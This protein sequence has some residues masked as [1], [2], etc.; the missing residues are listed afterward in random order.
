MRQNSINY[1]YSEIPLRII[2]LDKEIIIKRVR[3]IELIIK[4]FRQRW[5]HSVFP[6]TRPT[7]SGV[8]SL[9][10]CIWLEFRFS[11]ISM[12][13]STQSFQILFSHIF[14]FVGQH[15]VQ[16]RRRSPQCR[17]SRGFKRCGQLILN[18]SKRIKHS[19]V[20]KSNR[21]WRWSHAKK[22]HVYRSG[23]WKRRSR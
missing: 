2:T 9:E 5:R 4:L 6:R 15:N 16:P 1:D 20:A 18:R 11:Q 21:G 19:F 8:Y 14:T 10:F 23:I 22:S 3:T 12:P 7:W 13:P 17:Q